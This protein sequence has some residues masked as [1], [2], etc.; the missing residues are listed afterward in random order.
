MLFQLLAIAEDPFRKVS[1]GESA[2]YALLGF[3]VVIFGISFLILVVWLIGKGLEKVN[4]V[5]KAKKEKE[6]KAVENTSVTESIAVADGDEI[7]EETIA[8]ISAAIMAY[9][10]QTNPKCEFTVKRIKRI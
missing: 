4:A 10:Q 7:T 6:S 5:N 9:Y 2:L 8:V 3:L 1:V